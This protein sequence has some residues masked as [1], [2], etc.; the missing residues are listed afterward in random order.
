[1][2]FSRDE[3]LAIHRNGSFLFGQTLV[4]GIG[5]NQTVTRSITAFGKLEASNC[6]GSDFAVDG[7]T[8]TNAVM[9][10]SLSIELRERWVTQILRDSSFK[11]G[12]VMCSVKEGTCH[13]ASM[14][15]IFWE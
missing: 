6:V 15:H 10:S 4:T 5:I 14:G 12:G 3:C 8:F 13:S 9:Q 1:M 2:L 7:R 11:I